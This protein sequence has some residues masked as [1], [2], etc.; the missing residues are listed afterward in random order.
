MVSD[1]IKFIGVAKTVFIATY[2]CDFQNGRFQYTKLLSILREFRPANNF[3]PIVCICFL[4]SGSRKHANLI[5]I[6]SP[7]DQEYSSKYTRLE[8]HC[9]VDCS[10]NFARRQ[11]PICNILV[12]REGRYIIAENCQPVLHRHIN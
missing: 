3:S 12:R 5:V 8:G 1:W 2:L 9:D 10:S 4:L 7:K 11:K 6:E